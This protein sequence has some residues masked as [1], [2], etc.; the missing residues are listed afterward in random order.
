MPRLLLEVEGVVLDGERDNWEV[1]KI[2]P[3][4]MVPLQSLHV[5]TLATFLEAL[6]ISLIH[7]KCT[8]VQVQMVYNILPWLVK[9]ALS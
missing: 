3:E 8:L 6:G 7:R 5:R 9:F 1:C 4:G 2:E